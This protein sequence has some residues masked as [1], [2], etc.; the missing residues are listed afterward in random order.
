MLLSS[1]GLNGSTFVPV[2]LR[3]TMAAILYLPLTW[4]EMT[5]ILKVSTVRHLEHAGTVEENG[6]HLVPASTG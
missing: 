5:A 4:R 1:C 6:H 2:S 3:E